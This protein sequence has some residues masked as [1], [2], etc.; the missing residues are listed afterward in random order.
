MQ[1][2][3]TNL[4]LLT[5]LLAG[6][7]DIVGGPLTAQTFSTLYNFTGESDGAE[8]FA[9]LTL[10]SNTLYGTTPF[11]GDSGAGPV[12]AINPDGTG[13]KPLYSFNGLNDGFYSQ[14][15][16]VLSNLVLY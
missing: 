16:L 1:R 8:P 5:A 14:G 3:V 10:S 11:A 9:G 4:L 15:P 7:G 13:F 2:C 6:P 12:F